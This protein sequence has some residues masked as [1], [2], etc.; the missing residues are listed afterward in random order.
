MR[1]EQ[2][3]S[4]TLVL[5]AALRKGSFLDLTRASCFFNSL[6]FGA[7]LL[8]WTPFAFPR[9]PW[10]LLTRPGSRQQAVAP[11]GKSAPVTPLAALWLGQRAEHPLSLS[12]DQRSECD[13]TRG[14]NG[15]EGRAAFAFF[16]SQARSS[17]PEGFGEPRE[18]VPSLVMHKMHLCTSFCSDKSKCPGFTPSEY[19]IF[20][21]SL[22]RSCALKRN[23]DAV[24]SSHFHCCRSLVNPAFRIKR[25][26]WLTRLKNIL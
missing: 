15:E 11:L 6:Y 13:E 26:W 22:Y 24:I 2:D 10:G 3:A 7:A 1:R 18:P 4:A 23:T 14:W 16:H 12:W 17:S 19:F 20:V 5:S 21:P 25:S 9:S 8:S